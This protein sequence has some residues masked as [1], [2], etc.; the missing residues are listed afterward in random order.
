MIR[1]IQQL[2]S[3][4]DAESRRSVIIMFFFMI[5]SAAVEALGV[6]L[7][8]PLLQVI[9]DERRLS[10]DGIVADLYRLSGA[11]TTEAFVMICLGAIGI[12]YIFKAVLAFLVSHRNYETIYG[13]SARLSTY[14]YANYIRCPYTFHLKTNSA[15]LVRN[16]INLPV[17]VCG[18]LLNPMVVLVTE[19]LVISAIAGVLFVA[20]PLPTVGVAASLS[21]VAAA[22][23]FTVRRRL[24][25][26]GGETVVLARDRILW[27][28][29][30]MAAVKE[31][32]LMGAEEFVSN[33]YA[34]INRDWARTKALS[35]F[36]G[37]SPRPVFE[38]IVML[39]VLGGCAIL[40]VGGHRVS[41]LVGIVGLFGV[42]AVRLL[43]SLSK[44][45]YNIGN[46]KL[47][48]AALEELIRDIAIFKSDALEEARHG[49][50][51]I[52]FDR[53]IRL[54]SVGYYYP[55]APAAS[56]EAI[57]FAIPKGT[58]VAFVGSSG[59]GKT[60][61]TGIITGLL[62]PTSGRMLIDD[63][64]VDFRSR[65]WR[66]KI[67]YIPQEIYLLDDSIRRNIAFG[68]DDADIDDARIWKALAQAK[69][70][71]FVASLPDRLDCELG[72]RGARLS[73]GQRQR[74][75]IARALYHDP[76]I[77]V[78]DEATSALDAATEMAVAQSVRDLA[79][80][81]TIIIV[82]HRV[83]TVRD[84]DRV[85]YMSNGKIV[86]DGTFDQLERENTQFRK[87]V[88]GQPEVSSSV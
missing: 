10:G 34:K 64:E 48:A 62:V 15:N 71:Q 19:F 9:S 18:S 40:I 33:R 57:S 45:T 30:G 80:T 14:M 60:T 23:F 84:V 81:R 7:V 21:V 54:E 12:A 55:D 88:L 78:L 43:P 22:Y 66:R 47:N 76:E 73:G 63:V 59:A 16:I 72:E 44:V 4:L 35:S 6:T 27:T 67:G 53:E 39:L 31:I 75:A 2:W 46:L 32:K 1:T 3:V 8:L 38:L 58:T 11:G 68:E 65:E 77:L 82:A 61:L 50:M 42:A 70:D 24:Q 52:L 51:A 26:W 29:Q 83:S 36:V 28:N 86:A 37:D 25:A 56:L 79:G 13:A 20:Q 69:L 49:G 74:V 85:F 17:D 87:V 41:D 5:A